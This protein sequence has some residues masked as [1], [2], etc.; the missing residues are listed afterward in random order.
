MFISNTHEHV[1]TLS[2]CGIGQA[3][4]WIQKDVLQGKRICEWFWRGA[5]PGVGTRCSSLEANIEVACYT[6]NN[7]ATESS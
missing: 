7:G 4:T 3:W 1:C 5:H 6:W 2:L